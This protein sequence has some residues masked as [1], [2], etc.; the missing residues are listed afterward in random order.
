MTC[1]AEPPGSCGGQPIQPED[2]RTFDQLWQAGPT[3]PSIGSSGWWRVSPSAFSFPEGVVAVGGDL[4][5]ATLL[6]AYRTGMFPMPLEGSSQMVWWSPDPRGIL[7]LERF[8]PSRSL[9]RSIR[10]YEITV[11]RAFREVVEGC[12]DPSRPHGW[13]TPEIADAYTRLHELGWAHS[14]EVWFE[15]QLAGGMYGVGIGSFFAGESMFYRVR[16]ASKVAVAGMVGLLSECNEAVFDVQW[17]TP[18]LITLGAAEI[19]RDEYL[20][21][22]SVAVNIPGPFGYG[23]LV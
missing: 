2:R 6:A 9:R 15:G 5:P 8:L 23:R 16:D 19:D 14:V 13:I 4:D 3:E 20:R 7:E 10:R 22:I 11:D 1:S 17:V 18:H 21:R 12:A